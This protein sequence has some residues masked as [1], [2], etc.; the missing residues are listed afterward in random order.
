MQNAAWKRNITTG[1]KVQ[2]ECY[3]HVGRS[4]VGLNETD[5]VHRDRIISGET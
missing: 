4:I 2:A 3:A 1:I 5:A